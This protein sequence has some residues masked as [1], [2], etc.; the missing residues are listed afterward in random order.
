MAN[1]Y[2][3]EELVSN[4]ALIGHF[5]LGNQTFKA[6]QLITLAD[7]ELQTSLIS[8]IQSSR[9]GYY[10]TYRDY[11]PTPDGLYPI[12]SDAIG[13]ALENVQIGQDTGLMTLSL[14]DPS[15]QFSTVAPSAQIG[16]AQ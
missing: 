13:G 4:I 11:D 1:R 8:Q 7:R 2:T 16:R 6:D 3:T 10:L 9:G 14:L 15:A 12:P 5:P